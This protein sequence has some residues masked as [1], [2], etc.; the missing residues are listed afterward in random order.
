MIPSLKKPVS[1]SERGFGI[2]D[3]GELNMAE[4]V[5]KSRIVSED[6]LE[7]SLMEE[8]NMRLKSCLSQDTL[9]KQSESTEQEE[10]LYE[11]IETVKSSS[12]ITKS[13]LKTERTVEI[14]NSS[15]SSNI[16][17][18]HSDSATTENI[19]E[20]VQSITKTSS[21]YMDMDGNVETIKKVN[22]EVIY[23]DLRTEDHG[24]TGLV[25]E[26]IASEKTKP[27]FTLL[28]A[29]SVD[30]PEKADL[31]SAKD[32]MLLSTDDT[33]TLFFTQTV[34][35]PMLTPSEE[36]VDF[37]K[38]FRRESSA[39]S[40]PKDSS[41]SEESS[42]AANQP[43]L[44]LV[45]GGDV[46]VIA[47]IE[48]PPA[49]KT[50]DGKETSEPLAEKYVDQV[51]ENIYENLETMDESIYENL[52]DLKSTRPVTGCFDKLE[53]TSES[54]SE[55]LPE[56][57]S[58]I[59]Q[60]KMYEFA[61]DDDV[62]E[63]S[64]VYSLDK[65]VS[66][67]D[68]SNF[69][70]DP[71]RPEDAP[72]SSRKVDRFGVIQDY[73]NSEGAAEEDQEDEERARRTAEDLEEHQKAGY[74]DAE[75]MDYI[76]MT[77]QP[78]LKEK[79]STEVKTKPD[80]NGD[81]VQVQ[82]DETDDA[83]R[84][85]KSPGQ[86]R[87]VDEIVK[88]YI[89]TKSDASAKNRERDTETVPAKIVQNLTSQ[90]M[91]GADEKEDSLCKNK[92]HDV[93]QLKS[94]GIMKQINRFEQKDEIVEST[95][96]TENYVETTSF[97]S[98][99]GEKAM[100]KKKT[101][102]TR[103]EEKENISVNETNL[104]SFYNVSVKN[105]KSSFSKFDALQ[106]KNVLHIRSSDS[107]RAQEK[108]NGTGID[109][110]LCKCCGKQ[111]FQME[112]IKAE[113]AVWHKN[114]FRCHECNKQLNVDTYE[115]H[116]GT[117]YCKPHFKALF[118]PKA[119]DDIDEPPKTRKTEVIIREN[120]PLE[121]PPDVVRASDKP[122][123]G[124]EELQSLNVKER[125]H[126][127]EQH[128][129]SDSTLERT[130]VNVKRSPS[131]LSKLAKFQSKGMDIGVTDESLNGIPIEESS[132]DEEEENIPEGEDAELVRAKRVQKEKPFHFTGMSDVKNRFEHGESN[133]RDE[134]REERKQEI[135]SIRNKL[136]MGKQGK[137]KEAYQEAVMKSESSVNLKKEDIQ[138]CDTKTIKER[139]EKGEIVQEA[140][141][142]K[143]EEELEIY[144][145][146]ISKKSRSLFLEL[147]ANASK[148]PQLTTAAPKLEIKKA[149]EA[150]I[151]KSASQDTVKCT[152]QIDDVTVQTADIQQRFK[153]FETY[154]EPEKQRKQF[155]ITPPREGQVKGSTPERELYH[156]PDIVRADEVIEDSVIAKETHTATKMLNKFRQ[157]EE[158]MSKEPVP[159]GPKPLKRFTPPP[160]PSREDKSSEEEGSESEEE[161]VDELDQ[162][163][164]Q[165]VEDEDLI[166]AKKAARA[167]Q[168]TA[169][170]EKWEAQEIKKEQNNL[171][172]VN[173]DDQS[174]IE[175][176]KLLRERF[177]S[178]KATHIEVNKQPKIKVNRFVEISNIMEFCEGCEKRVYPLEKISVHGQLFH[179]SCFKCKECNTILRMDSYTYNQGRLY[180]TPHF[181]RLFITK[182][183][184][185]S[186]FG[187]EGHKEKWN[188]AVA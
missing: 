94:V 46:E 83:F 87:I 43:D 88:N 60:R 166:E 181:K 119:V 35:S 89:V 44:V 57:V 175:S 99:M 58:Q 96:I 185:D 66:D 29:A 14:L 72:I 22:T 142:E 68:S 4:T 141:D 25:K 50:P 37:L 31:K 183:N 20:N 18:G 3:R 187:F 109:T 130:Q 164:S 86:T 122:D 157:M 54:L 172:N 128:Q 62:T 16:S 55:A 77:E 178:M 182:G 36:N 26:D 135:Q 159:Q 168:L 118:A 169:K 167:K 148:A 34:T 56:I 138:V 102:K 27:S 39:N 24:D 133:S 104:E 173:E 117:L 137:M 113:K 40:S 80:E 114:C 126:V 21:E 179:K 17:N 10:T 188:S 127:F 165:K 78:N 95:Q 98:N 9:E 33:S 76:A 82:E 67:S 144:E 38:G 170:F 147:D 121:L 52:E 140:K 149:R 115:S 61:E 63:T 125:F 7:E 105:L 15:N 155:R 100:K 92:K 154:R 2:L 116:E 106:K 131:I 64:D 162:I 13:F 48:K 156:D 41:R 84:E 74:D 136:F 79:E 134:R 132:S 107:T 91:K 101:K 12:T 146:E 152:E 177:E 184:Y 161:E 75:V 28:T 81:G 163:N 32:R 23:E 120:Q 5:K 42:T 47:G 65:Q 1:F 108:F 6:N 145:S 110:T 59:E 143:D 30:T 160:E 73:I 51:Q 123:L 97:D 71:S 129:S 112:Q 158:N 151:Q 174:Q 19:Y 53:N 49:E 111:V 93:N 171:I 70:L 124:L 85:I 90:F 186:A 176:T 8:F 180:C 45:G 11:N 139:F 103:K 150:Y 69:V 153:F